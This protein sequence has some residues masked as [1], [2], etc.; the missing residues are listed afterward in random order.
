MNQYIEY[1]GTELE[2][3]D[4]TEAC[5]STIDRSEVCFSERDGY[6]S[7]RVKV[8]SEKRVRRIKICLKFKEDISGKNILVH[9]FFNSGFKKIEDI[10]NKITSKYFFSVLDEAGEGINFMNT[11]PAKFDSDIVFEKDEVSLETVLPYSY[12]GEVISEEFLISEKLPYTEAYLYNAEK[13]KCDKVWENVIGW[14]SWDYYFTSINEAAVKENVDFIHND[15]LL[16]EKIKYIAIDDGWQQR[17]GDW[18]EGSRFP[19]GL[20]ET[21]KYITGK[22]YCA[23]IWTA[24]TR[25]HYLCGT[26]MRR[27]TFLI[28]NINGDPAMDEE[29]Y[30]ADPTHPEGEKY[31]KEIY[32]YLK[33]C[34]FTYYKIDFI[35]NLLSGDFFYDKTC[36]HFDALRRLIAIIR[37]CV[38]KDCHMMGCS[39]PYAFGGADID[40]RRV[41]LDIHNT[42]KHIIKCSEIYL[43]QFA[44]HRRIYQNDFD[45]LI[46]RG[47]DT[48]GEVCINVLN[49]LAGKYKSEPTEAF[50]WRDGEDFSYDEA[51]IW[52]ASILMSGSSVML[53]DRLTALNEK[54]VRLIRKTLEYAD[55]ISAI[56]EANGAKLPSV[57]RKDG[58]IYIFNYSD[59]E[60]E[61]SVRA[62]GNYREIFDEI[63]YENTHGVLHVKLRPHT[64]LALKNI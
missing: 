38:G 45:Y 31:I 26:V 30:I 28:R 32:T 60:K 57:W 22:G 3:A 1:T 8:L 13:C 10:K 59:E 12:E 11:I 21:V 62:D 25:L 54:G 14:G 29:F 49:P 5:L 6:T 61:F 52:C 50:R 20:S 39:L 24:P 58:W 48:S 23:G 27:N 36:G 56:P 51:K 4:G 37:E 15:K 46:V 17:E 19:S 34:G 44:S 40:S 53:S 43:P 64:C 9:D 42:W 63:N 18:K 16:R 41:G 55:F 7:V 33:Q 2:Y 35:A 47:K